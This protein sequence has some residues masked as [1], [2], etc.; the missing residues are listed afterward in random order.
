MWDTLTHRD[1]VERYNLWIR[2]EGFHDNIEDASIGSGSLT[3]QEALLIAQ[4]LCKVFGF[5]NKVKDYFETPS[6]EPE[7]EKDLGDEAM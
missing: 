3:E 7:H 1:N 5:I 6:E 4:R 2:P